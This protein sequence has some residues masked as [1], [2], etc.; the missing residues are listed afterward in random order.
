MTWESGSSDQ[1]RLRAGYAVLSVGIFIL[2]CAWVLYATRGPEGLGEVAV[3]HKK[4]E[5]PDPGRVWPAVSAGMVLYGFILIIVLF[6]SVF[7]FLRISR[8]YRRQLLKKPAKPTP[9][10]DVWKMHKVPHQAEDDDQ[11]D[12]NQPQETPG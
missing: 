9:T 2:L 8:H 12:G 7:A 5:P 1:Q 10:T 3:Q 6:V 11:P 4:L